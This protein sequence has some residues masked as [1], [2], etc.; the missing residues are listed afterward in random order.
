[1]VEKN[2]KEA[3]KPKKKRCFLQLSYP[4]SK[5]GF[6]KSSCFCLQFLLDTRLFMINI[7]NNTKI[8]FT[9]RDIGLLIDKI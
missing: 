2:K 1:M 6:I 4:L 7:I 3:N 5:I 8:L 9:S